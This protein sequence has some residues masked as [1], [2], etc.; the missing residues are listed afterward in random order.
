[1]LINTPTITIEVTSTFVMI[2][3]PNCPASLK[4]DVCNDLDSEHCPCS[5]PT[6]HLKPILSPEDVYDMGSKLQDAV[7]VAYRQAFKFSTLP[8]VELDHVLVSYSGSGPL[9]LHSP[10]D[11]LVRP[12]LPHNAFLCSLEDALMRFKEDFYQR[13]EAIIQSYCGDMTVRVAI[14]TRSTEKSAPN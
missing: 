9:I 10:Y 1:M 7:I 3:E 8:D 13:A 4:Q 11:V 14:D 12:Y 5:P 6:K 2:E